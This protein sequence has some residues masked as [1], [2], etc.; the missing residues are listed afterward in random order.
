MHPQERRKRIADGELGLT[1][2]TISWDE[3]ERAW[4]EYAKRYGREQ[5]AERI[6]QRGGFCYA[7]LC[8]LLG[9]PP[10]TWIPLAKGE[11]S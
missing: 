11:F 3:H 8:E 1:D 5:S 10:A 2:G 9:C 6:N 7:E 4:A